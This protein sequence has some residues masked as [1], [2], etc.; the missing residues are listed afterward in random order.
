M[1]GTT[2]MTRT[3]ILLTLGLSAAACG[4][5]SSDKAPP[6]DAAASAAADTQSYFTVPEAQRAHLGIA[7]AHLTDLPSTIHTTGTV[8]WDNDH[9]TQAITQVNGP[10]TRI[11]VDL[12]THVKA[13]DPLLYVA[14]PDIASAVSSYRKAKNRLDQAQRTLNRNKDLLDHKAIAQRDFDDSQ[15][16]YND[17]ATDLQTS[18]QSLKILGVSDADLKDAEAQTGAVRA[19]LPMRSPIDGVVVQK[20]V[21]PGQVIQAGVTQ[22][23]MISNIST[24]WV[25]AHVYDKDLSSIT[26]GDAAEVRTS[27]IPDVFRGRVASVGELLDP[28]TR[29]TLVRIVTANPRGALRKDLF[30]DVAIAGPTRHKV[31]VVPTTAVLYDEQN[32]PFVYIDAGQ[33]RVE[34][35]LVSLGTQ[36]GSDTEITAGLKADDRV[37]G[38]GSLFLQFARSIGK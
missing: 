31:L 19:E 13:G 30:V 10:I 27:A 22:A 26:M 1:K 5:A 33:G 9:T 28:A 12:G 24:V 36:P 4:G 37:V 6:A 38:Q 29:T 32:M 8:D 34:Q 17:A 11:V 25:Q 18:M 35:R 2:G 16:D 15:A 14:S 7:T 21:F 20:L 3:C 23:F